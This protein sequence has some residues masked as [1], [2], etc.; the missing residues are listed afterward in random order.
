MK[1]ERVI[2]EVETVEDAKKVEE[3]VKTGYTE[4]TIGTLVQWMAVEDD[5]VASYEI[6]AAKPENASRRGVLEQLASESKRNLDALSE[7][8]KSFESLDRARVKRIILL[9][10]MSA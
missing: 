3:T 4:P 8:R 10:S 5:L 6:L 9:G 7:L 2:A 1:R